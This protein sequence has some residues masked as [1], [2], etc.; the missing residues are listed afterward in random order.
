MLILSSFFS[1]LANVL[2]R[3]ECL[4]TSIIIHL[5]VYGISFHYGQ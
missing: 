1:D 5:L 2:P 3:I 4:D